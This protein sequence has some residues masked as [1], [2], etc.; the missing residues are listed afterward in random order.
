[1][2]ISP[3]YTL[4]EG[5]YDHITQQLPWKQGQVG[6][7]IY[8]LMTP[9]IFVLF[10]FS[11]SHTGWHYSISQWWCGEGNGWQRRGVQAAE[12]TWRVEWQHVNGKCT[13]I[14]ISLNYGV[15]SVL[16][17]SPTAISS[18]V[19]FCTCIHVWAIWPWQHI[20]GLATIVL[21]NKARTCALA[22]CTCII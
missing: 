14:A 8:K 19:K 10:Y 22:T 15:I 21:A 9:P 4:R 17:S 12:G 13:C 20:Y 16:N 6:Y 18:N 11:L 5:W 7:I 3:L 2:T 1:M